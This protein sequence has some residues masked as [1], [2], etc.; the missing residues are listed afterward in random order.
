MKL[1]RLGLSSRPQILINVG[2]VIEKKPR[3][4]AEQKSYVCV[5]TPCHVCDVRGFEDA[6]KE[7]TLVQLANPSSVL[8]VDVFTQVNIL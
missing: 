5:M 1:G 6:W 4:T 8:L 3:L 2:W 7:R